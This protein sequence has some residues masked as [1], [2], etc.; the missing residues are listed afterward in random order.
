MRFFVPLANDPRHSE[1]LYG[2]IRERLPDLDP[3]IS[4]KRIYSLKFEHNGSFHRLVVGGHCQVLGDAGP[5]MAIFETR[6]GEHYVCTPKRGAF[7]G[8]PFRIDRSS[9]SGVEEFSALA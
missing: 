8:E 3:G 1:D 9:V 5:V 2:K 7:E 4:A 6:E